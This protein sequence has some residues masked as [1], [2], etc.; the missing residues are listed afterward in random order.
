MAEPA[1]VLPPPPSSPVR[2]VTARPRGTIP[3]PFGEPTGVR[4]VSFVELQKIGDARGDLVVAELDKHVPFLV[5]RMYALVNVPS[6]ADRG[7]HAHKELEQVLVV[8]SGGFELVVDDGAHRQSIF[9]DEQTRGV[10][11]RPMV[12]RELRRFRPGTVC[13]VL[14]SSVYEE[15]DYLRDYDSFKA[16]LRARG[17]DRPSPASSGVHRLSS[18]YPVDP[19]RRTG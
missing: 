17:L 12:W 18:V 16:E 1:T 9:L 13:V 5:E 4:R 10:Y 11:L 2:L 19:A 6:N 15:G 14:A 7:G 3:P 8:L